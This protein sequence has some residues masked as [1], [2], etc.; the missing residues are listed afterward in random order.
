M[1]LCPSQIKT[2]GHPTWAELQQNLQLNSH[3]F[4]TDVFML[5]QFSPKTWGT[6]HHISVNKSVIKEGE[7]THSDTRKYL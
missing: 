7:I 4:H 5:G 2:S 1:Q 3:N 6:V